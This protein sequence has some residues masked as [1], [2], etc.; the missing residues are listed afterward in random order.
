MTEYIPSK[1]WLPAK[2]VR[3]RYGVSD[4]TLWRWLT[5]RG[6]GFPSPIRINGRR[7]WD[8]EELD[9]FDAKRREATDARVS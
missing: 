5:S 2:R 3:A 4:M 7:F 6:L 1:T 9:R 8:Q